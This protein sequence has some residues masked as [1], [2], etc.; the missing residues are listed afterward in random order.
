MALT[1]TELAMLEH[2]LEMDRSMHDALVSRIASIDIRG[3]AADV[4][5]RVVTDPEASDAPVEPNLMM[6]AAACLLIG[7]GGGCL[8]VYI[9]DV[10]DDRFRT[11][12]ELKEQLGVPV[13]AMVRQLP[14]TEEFAPEAL[15]AHLVAPAIAPRHAPPAAILNRLP[16]GA[17]AQRARGRRVARHGSNFMIV[18]APGVRHLPR[19]APARAARAAWR[20]RGRSATT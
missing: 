19:A 11:P 2:D 13:L 6:V 12:E 3:E 7:A 8:L 17:V 9:L 4:R 5:V 20:A 1:D 14:P 16:A 15:V 18:C 10:I